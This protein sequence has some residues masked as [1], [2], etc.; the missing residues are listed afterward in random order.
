MRRAIALLALVALSGA[1]ALGTYRALESMKRSIPGAH[2]AASGAR[3]RALPGTLFVA[4]GGRLY[5]FRAGTFRQLTGSDGW[6]Q[7][8]LSPDGTRLVAVR[9]SGN[10]SDIYLLGLDGRVE[11]QLTHNESPAVERNHWAFYPRFSADGQTIFYSYDPKD[12]YNSFRVDLAVYAMPVAA[13]AR[14]RVWTSPNHYT[15]GDVQPV[16]LKSGALLYTKYSIDPQGTVHSQL[17]IQARPLSPG[18]ALTKPE[19]DC[20]QPNVSPGQDVVVMVCTH[21]SGSPSLE[22]APLDLANYALGPA[23]VLVEGQQAAAPA[24][25]PAGTEVAYFA[26]AAGGGSLQLWTVKLAVQPS[27]AAAGSPGPTASPAGAPAGPV[28]QQVTTNLAFDS[29]APP[30]WT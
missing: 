22:V 6:M 30:A 14:A 7:P 1:A 8:A 26:P 20:S 18:A 29:T 27:P 12:P 28:R 23:T 9:R 4:Q 15:G 13:P 25:S 17:W 2:A 3:A 24:F 11:A 5:S 21:G 19:D 10:F 16:P